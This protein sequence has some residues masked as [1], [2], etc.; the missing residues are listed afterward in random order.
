MSVK[1]DNLKTGFRIGKGVLFYFLLVAGMAPTLI[2]TLH[3]GMIYGKP[4]KECVSGNYDLNVMILPIYTF[5]PFA[6]AFAAGKLR[7]GCV[8][9]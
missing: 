9:D 3:A 6:C 4:C 2:T 1:N 8:D 7:S 5:L